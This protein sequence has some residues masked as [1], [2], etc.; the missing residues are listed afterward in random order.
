MSAIN[1]NFRIQFTN[2]SQEDCAWKPHKTET[3]A[4]SA[5]SQLVFRVPALSQTSERGSARGR[6]MT[7][8]TD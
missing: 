7:N 5:I 4:A 2:K 1:L 6:Q 8:H 3:V